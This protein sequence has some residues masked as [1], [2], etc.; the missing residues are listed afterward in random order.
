MANTLSKA[1]DLLLAF[2]LRETNHLIVS[3]PP[4]ACEA[5]ERLEQLDYLLAQ[6]QALGLGTLEMRNDGPVNNASD[7][8]FLSQLYTESFYFFGFRFLEIVNSRERPIPPLHGLRCDGIRN[9]RNR[10]IVHP[11]KKG[12]Q[13]F[14]RSWGFSAD[15]GPV[16]MPVRRLDDPTE[17]YDRGL[18]SNADELAGAICDRL[19]EAIGQPSA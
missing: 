11:D 10:L 16:M 6:V 8:V 19:V 7:P 14:T 15:T 2:Q 1:V 17:F 4:L 3:F 13:G 12:G 5:L 9:V 18:Y